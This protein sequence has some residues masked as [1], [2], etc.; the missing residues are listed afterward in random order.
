MRSARL[1][2]RMAVW[3]NALLPLLGENQKRVVLWFVPHYARVDDTI[4]WSVFKNT[5]RTDAGEGGGTT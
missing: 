2:K 5:I 1:K 4:P 3:D